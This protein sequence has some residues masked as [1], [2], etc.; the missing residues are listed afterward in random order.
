MR[1]TRSTKHHHA[2]VFLRAIFDAL[3][4]HIALAA[5]ALLAGLLCALPIG[6]ASTPSEGYSA[7]SPYPK[8]FRTVALP[9]FRNQSYMRSF[10][11]DLA[12]AL[13]KEVEQMTPYKVTSEASADTVLRG[14]ITAIDM[15][16]L[17]KDPATGLANEMMVRMKVNFEWVD[18]RS[19]EA[20]VAREGVEST[21]LFV[22]SY[23]SREPLELGR[24]AAVQLLARELV[25]SM[26][27]QW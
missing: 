7:T 21:A 11:F 10:E 24:F 2:S 19:G 17:S 9:I 8:K 16:E 14:T 22:P 23:P 5:T 12:D 25:S 1:A 18:L 4:V 20:I 26:Q 13:V 6:C 15:V 27:S 3:R